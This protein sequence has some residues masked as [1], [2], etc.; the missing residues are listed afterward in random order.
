MAPR[1]VVCVTTFSLDDAL[2]T[3][4]IAGFF[5]GLLYLIVE[6]LTWRVRRVAEIKALANIRE[7]YRRSFQLSRW[8]VPKK[9]PHKGSQT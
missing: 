8:L 6:I 9:R 1:I 3:A 5:L 2:L 7:L 4:I